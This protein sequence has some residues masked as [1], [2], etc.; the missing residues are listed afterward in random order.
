MITVFKIFEIYGLD[1][2]SVK[3]VRHGNK[4][5]PVLSSFKR[6]HSR[7]EAYQSYQKPGKF[8]KSSSIAVFAP[9]FKTTALF[10][11]LWNIEGCIYNSKFTKDIKAELKKFQLPED[12]FYV[13]DRYNL[14]KNN[15]LD[16]LSE[17]LVIEWGSATVAWVQSKDKEVVEIKGKKSIGDFHSFSQVDIEYQD[18]KMLI[19]YPDT[20]LTWVKALSS[21]NGIYLIKDKLSGKLYVG[22]AYGDKGIYGRW[23]AYA[24]NGHGG[25]LEL[26]ELDPTNFQFSIL[27]IVSPTTTADGVIE[28]ENRW[29]EKLG[30]RQFGLNRN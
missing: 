15:M 13:A 22:S 25:N 18:L 9:Y 1:P 29:K 11:G 3:L 20:N 27:E 5:I 4:E 30:T 8:G 6:D 24:Q 2:M 26:K 7:F 10:L 21:V 23:S 16:D 12:W 17:R 19:Q 28:C 14:Q